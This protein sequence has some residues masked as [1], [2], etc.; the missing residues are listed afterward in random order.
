MPSALLSFHLRASPF[1]N[2]VKFEL[3][4]EGVG[5]RGA[6]V[7]GPSEGVVLVRLLGH[8]L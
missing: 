3:A 4:V 5:G 8:P 1:A 7:N 6:F 2:L